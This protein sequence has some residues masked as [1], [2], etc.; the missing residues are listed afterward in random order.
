MIGGSGFPKKL[1]ETQ[2]L[3]TVQVHEVPGRQKE[4]SVRKSRKKII[5]TRGEKRE[6]RL[7]HV[8]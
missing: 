7:C 8:R 1:V 4:S 6:R 2:G 5:S 3:D